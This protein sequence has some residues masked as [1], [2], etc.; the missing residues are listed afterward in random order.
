MDNLEK[1]L[2]KG[3]DPTKYVGMA[4]QIE[5]IESQDPNIKRY[6]A[7]LAAYFFRI[8]KYISELS[9]HANSVKALEKIAYRED[10][11]KKTIW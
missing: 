6:G 4:I 1:K 7:M 5:C 8:D 10:K 3:N 11:N 2:K 9:F